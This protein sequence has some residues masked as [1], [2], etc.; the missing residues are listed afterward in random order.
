MAI[1][2]FRLWILD[3]LSSVQVLDSA[4]ADFSISHFD[5]KVWTRTKICNKKGIVIPDN[6]GSSPG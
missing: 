4:I 1:L 6:P 2:D 5:W 3:C